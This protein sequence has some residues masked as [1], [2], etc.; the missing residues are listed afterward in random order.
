MNF[1]I[2]FKDHRLTPESLLSYDKKLFA[3]I[4]QNNDLNL[5]EHSILTG[6][7]YSF[8][9]LLNVFRDVIN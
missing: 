2:K 1:K 5:P 7:H 4:K 8:S 3:W 6:R 9:N